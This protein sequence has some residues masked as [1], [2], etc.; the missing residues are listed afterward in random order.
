[1]LPKAKPNVHKSAKSMNGLLTVK[2]LSFNQFP[3]KHE[4]SKV[5]ISVNENFYRSPKKE[6]PET[7]LFARRQNIRGAMERIRRFRAK[8]VHKLKPTAKDLNLVPKITK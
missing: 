1:M 8:S 4:V 3:S 7:P 6:R 5:N 2:S